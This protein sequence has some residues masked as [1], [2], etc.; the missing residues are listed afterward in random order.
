MSSS[1]GSNIA[2]LTRELPGFS[3]LDAQRAEIEIEQRLSAIPDG[4][5][6]SSLCR[7]AIASGLPQKADEDATAV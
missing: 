5:V 6:T 3:R 4:P 7:M 1:P 2:A